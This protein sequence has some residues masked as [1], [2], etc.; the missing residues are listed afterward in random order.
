ML[1]GDRLAP[2]QA[3][4][5]ALSIEQTLIDQPFLQTFCLPGGGKSEVVADMERQ[6]REHAKKIAAALE[7]YQER[8]EDSLADA[9]AR[10]S[11]Y[12]DS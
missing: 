8:P 4:K 6:N 2:V 3:L 10:A 1:E 11:T 9:R 7:D 12:R 5:L